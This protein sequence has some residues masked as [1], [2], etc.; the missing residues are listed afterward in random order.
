MVAIKKKYLLS[1]ALV[2]QQEENID[3]VQFLA[4]RIQDLFRSS[5]VNQSIANDNK[6]SAELSNTI[7]SQAAIPDLVNSFVN[8]CRKTWT[9]LPIGTNVGLRTCNP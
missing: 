6:N 2:N 9:K 4:G 7:H 8:T 3:P 1:Q 5:A